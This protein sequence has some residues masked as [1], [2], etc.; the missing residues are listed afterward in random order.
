M[1]NKRFL[2]SIV[3]FTVMAVQVFAQSTTSMA[4]KDNDNIPQY[5]YSEEEMDKVSDYIK[6]QYGEFDIVAHELVSPDIHCDIAIVPPTDDQPYYK[7]VTMGAGAFKMNVPEDLKSDVY[8]RAEYV[9]FLPADWNIKSD[10][11]EDYWPIR[12]LKTVAR[13]PV[14]MDDWLFYRHTVNLTDDESPVAE[15]TGFNSCVLFI[16]FGK[17][18]KPVEPL[19]LDLSDKEVAFFQL[20]PLYPEEL[21][22]KLEHSF[23]ELEDIMDDD[24]YDPVVDIHRENYCK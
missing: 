21:E 7:L 16:S 14:S 22:F 3:C 12:M 1:N 23:D 19:K 17:G 2:T 24:L 4:E 20:V 11:E 10:K 18:N 6:Q 8:E 5:S 15:N 13:L 9:V